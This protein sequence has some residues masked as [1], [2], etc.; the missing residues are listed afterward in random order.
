[1]R[2]RVVRVRVRVRIRI[3]LCA[4]HHSALTT[5]SKSGRWPSVYVCA[6][7]SVCV[8]MHVHAYVYQEWKIVVCP[9]D[10]VEYPERDGYKERFPSWCRVPRTLADMLGGM[11][12]KC[13]AKLRVDGHSEMIREELVAGRMYTGPMYAKYNTVLRS[14]SKDPQMLKLAKDLTK[15]NEYP[16]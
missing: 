15:G 4:P 10:G 9:E 16:T 11:E 6:R 12:E 14:K 7:V 3:P 2:V 8:C 13:N 5:P 1:M